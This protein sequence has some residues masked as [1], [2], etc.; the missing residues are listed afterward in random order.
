[1]SQVISSSTGWKLQIPPDQLQ[2]WTT[3]APWGARTEFCRLLTVQARRPPPAPDV[4]GHTQ[5]PSLAPS[6]QQMN[7]P[8]HS[9]KRT[10]SGL[11]FKGVTSFLGQLPAS[12]PPT[13]WFSALHLKGNHFLVQKADWGP[14]VTPFLFI[15][16]LT[17]QGTL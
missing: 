12:G 1:M 11:C 6:L 5:A 7:V 3:M 2:V 4:S 8:V 17:A 14:S 10:E 13:W 16:L 15:H 9:G